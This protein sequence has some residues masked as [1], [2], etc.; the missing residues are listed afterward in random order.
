MPDELPKEIGR[1]TV[2]LGTVE[3]EVVQLDDGR[4]LVT[5]ES[6]RAVLDWLAS[7]ASGE[8]DAEGQA[9]SDVP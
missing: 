9:E 8:P 7:G 4:R 5:E 1:G 2:K 6:L 3:I